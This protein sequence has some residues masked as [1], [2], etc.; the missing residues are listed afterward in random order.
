MTEPIWMEILGTLAG[1]MA[2]EMGKP[3]RDGRAEIEKSAPYCAG[4]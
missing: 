2:L 1:L 3:I 4:T